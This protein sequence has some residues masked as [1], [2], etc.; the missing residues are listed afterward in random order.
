MTDEPR[1]LV[2]FPGWP[3]LPDS[4]DLYA[5]REDKRDEVKWRI[6]KE[7]GHEE[8]V[9]GACGDRECLRCGVGLNP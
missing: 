5:D 8:H 4:A 6:C 3:T 9:C 7:L 1:R 2:I